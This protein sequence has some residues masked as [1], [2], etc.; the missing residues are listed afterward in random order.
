[1]SLHALLCPVCAQLPRDAV[2]LMPCQ[3]HTC[4]ACIPAQ[5]VTCPICLARIESV[6]EHKLVQALVREL[7]ASKEMRSPE[8]IPPSEWKFVTPSPRT[9]TPQAPPPSPKQMRR[10]HNKGA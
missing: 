9:H 7:E 8:H 1:M 4:A 6:S 2:L 10:F 3:H 5:A